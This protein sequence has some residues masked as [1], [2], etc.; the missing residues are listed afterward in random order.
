MV[1]SPLPPLPSTTIATVRG[2]VGRGLPL[3]DDVPLPRNAHHGRQQLGEIV[4]DDSFPTL[5]GRH[6]LPQPPTNINVFQAR[7]LAGEETCA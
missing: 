7:Q 2:V 4:A 6:S 1:S 5:A 3:D